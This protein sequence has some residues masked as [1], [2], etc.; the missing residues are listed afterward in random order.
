MIESLRNPISNHTARC[1]HLDEMSCV[2]P[3][4]VA[5]IIVEREVVSIRMLKISCFRL[6]LGVFVLCLWLS[7]CLARDAYK[8]HGRVELC[9][10]D[11]STVLEDVLSNYL[12]EQWEKFWYKF[13]W[14]DVPVRLVWKVDRSVSWHPLNA[15][16]TWK[17]FFKPHLEHKFL[18]LAQSF[19][20][21]WQGW[22]S[23]INYF[24]ELWTRCNIEGQNSEH[25]VA[26][27][28]AY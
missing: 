4:L 18:Q 21:I 20:K 27:R 2:L 24:F 5:W 13:L 16:P 3:K 9:E 12:F 10:L 19:H 11:M 28:I 14:H 8:V 23:V 17:L 1:L 26:L 6:I 25:L 15:S 22:F 7:C